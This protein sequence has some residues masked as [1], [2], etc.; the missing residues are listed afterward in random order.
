MR[1]SDVI[2]LPQPDRLRHPSRLLCV[3][4]LW[5]SMWACIAV[6][7]RKRT[8]W[9]QKRAVVTPPLTGKLDDSQGVPACPSHCRCA[10][11]KSH[12]HSSGQL[13]WL[14]PTGGP[15]A[16]P[17]TT[18]AA[19]ASPRYTT[20]TTTTTTSPTQQVKVR[21]P[22]QGFPAGFFAQP[23]PTLTRP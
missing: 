14:R 8:G 3:V 13:P 15:P 17:S 19:A 6:L 16:P 9:V 2:G 21:P 4:D 5:T 20:T 23:A 1:G 22:D 10:E 12:S 11:L 7:G 18:A